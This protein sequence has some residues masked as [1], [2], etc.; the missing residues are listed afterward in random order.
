MMMNLEAEGGLFAQMTTEEESRVKVL[1][2]TA[3]AGASEDV[4]SLCARL[5]MGARSA[6][7]CANPGQ[8]HCAVLA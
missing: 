8:N 1:L 4:T 2:H 7:T 6:H 5:H 3:G